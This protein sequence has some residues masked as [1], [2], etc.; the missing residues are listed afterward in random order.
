MFLRT[1]GM[2]VVVPAFTTDSSGK[3][4]DSSVT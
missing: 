3:D 1:H 4:T 2:D